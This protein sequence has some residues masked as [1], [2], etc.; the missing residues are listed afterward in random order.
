MTEAPEADLVH[1]QI[2]LQHIPVETGLHL[3]A[4]M[5]GKVRVGGFLAINFPS[6]R[7]C[8]GRAALT[9][10]CSAMLLDAARAQPRTRQAA[11]C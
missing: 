10:P 6:R 9:R 4:Q 8:P 11:R 2:V 7:I 1:S 5:W 3:I